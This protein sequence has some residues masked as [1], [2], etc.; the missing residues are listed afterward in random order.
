HDVDVI[1]LRLLARRRAGTALAGVGRI[2]DAIRRDVLALFVDTPRLELVSTIRHE[3]EQALHPVAVGVERLHIRQG[4]GLRREG[5][6]R[7]AVSFATFPALARLARFEEL[8]RNIGHWHCAL[9]LKGQIGWHPPDSS[10]ASRKW[11]TEFCHYWVCDHIA[12]PAVA[13]APGAAGVRVWQLISRGGSHEGATAHRRRMLMLAI[14]SV[15]DLPVVRPRA[16]G[17]GILVRLWHR[18]FGYDR[19]RAQEA[20]MGDWCDGH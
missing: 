18:A 3:A 16:G 7:V 5:R 20:V 12:S 14:S 9:L 15:A 13:A 10:R 6:V 11:S 4:L 17:F 19:P 8:H 1:G 2:E